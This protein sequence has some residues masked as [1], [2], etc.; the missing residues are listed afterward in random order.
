[1]NPGPG[2]ILVTMSGSKITGLTRKYLDQSGP[3]AAVANLTGSLATQDQSVMSAVYRVLRE[4]RT[5]FLHLT[6][7]AGAV[8]RP[9]ASQ[10]G[11]AYAQPDIV[12][13]AGSRGDTRVLDARWK[14]ALELARRHGSAIVMLRAS[15]A[16]LAWLPGA[17]SAKRL[18]SV[19]IVPLAA[20]LRR[21]PEL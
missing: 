3:V 7:A 14:R 12:L 16:A 17:L 9:L 4:R 10:L 18:G 20:L 19:E 13:E 8:C 21:P 11:V 15:E 1:V 6:P 2:A 5:P